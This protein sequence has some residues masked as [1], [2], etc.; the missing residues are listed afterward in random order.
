[1]GFGFFRAVN[2]RVS[3][4]LVLCFSFQSNTHMT[5]LQ[6]QS[7]LSST[8]RSR[9]RWSQTIFQPLWRLVWHSWA[10]VHFFIPLEVFLEPLLAYWVVGVETW[11]WTTSLWI[12][13]TFF[14]F[15]FYSQCLG[16][17]C[18]QSS[19]VK[20]AI[21][22]AASSLS[23]SEALHF[24]FELFYHIIVT[25]TYPQCEKPCSW[26][27]TNTHLNK[28]HLHTLV[29]ELVECREGMRALLGVIL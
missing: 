2:Q 7:A 13:I 27:Q 16:C 18:T 15:Y 1:M 9:D 14:F 19:P 12:N 24:V 23:F 21:F 4:R 10:N 28:D 29:P 3:W 17:E 6:Q 5:S 26:G 25:C 22:I 8:A 11:V 20:T